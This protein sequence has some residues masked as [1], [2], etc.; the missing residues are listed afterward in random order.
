MDYWWAFVDIFWPYAPEAGDSDEKLT[1]MYQNQLLK[2]RNAAA[3]IE[4][5]DD[6]NVIKTLL[7]KWIDAER[8][9]RVALEG[10]LSA[11]AGLAGGAA[12]LLVAL[13][14]NTYLRALSQPLDVA[15][16]IVFFYIVVQLVRAAICS[17]K[18]LRP[19]SVYEFS[20]SDLYPGSVALSVFSASFI[21]RCGSIHR[22][23]AQRNNEKGT[24]LQCAYR[25]LL[26]SAAGVMLVIFLMVASVLYKLYA[27]GEPA[28][29]HHTDTTTTGDASSKGAT[30]APPVTATTEDL[31]NHPEA[32]PRTTSTS[33]GPG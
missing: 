18:G 2:Y 14:G 25:A 31:F 13:L 6:F 23:Y 5:I 19:T 3:K 11:L 9:K 16:F 8:T 22:S 7:E 15:L 4:T 28:H 12:A 26:N 33:S 29:D 21:E 27:Y 17:I 20:A 24:F 1:L 10:R 30:I 32:N